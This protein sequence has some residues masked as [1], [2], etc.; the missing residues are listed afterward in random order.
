M[1]GYVSLSHIVHPVEE[2]FLGNTPVRFLLRSAFPQLINANFV[3]FRGWW[4]PL[5]CYSRRQKLAFRFRTP[6]L[7]HTIHRI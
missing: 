7:W 3:N 5:H 4:M 1:W 6:T 2:K